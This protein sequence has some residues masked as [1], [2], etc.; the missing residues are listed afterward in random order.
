VVPPSREPL[1]TVLATPSLVDTEYTVTGSWVE[2]VVA[3]VWAI[4]L[5]SKKYHMSRSSIKAKQ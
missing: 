3:S 1:G 5:R 4:I 2:S